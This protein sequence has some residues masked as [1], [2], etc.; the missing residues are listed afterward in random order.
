VASDEKEIGKLTHVLVDADYALKAI[1]VNEDAG[2][3]GRWLS[4]GSFLVNNEFIVP[5]EA[6]KQAGRDRIQLNLSSADARKLQPY[7][8]YREKDESLTE[9]AEDLAGAFGSGPEVPHWMEQVANKPAGELEIDG[10]EN[11]MLGHTGKKLGTVKSVLFDDD[12]LVGVVL[13]PDGLFRKEVILPR[14]F[15]SRSD[16]AA[17]F[18]QIDDNDLKHL[19][20]F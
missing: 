15:L 10:G 20:P 3:S 5:R 12:Q 14:R 9:G 2:F 13:L 19:K 7:L 4:P 11:V 8:R 16:D 18:A 1:V 17:L 6:I